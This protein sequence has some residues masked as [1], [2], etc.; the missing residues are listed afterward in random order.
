MCFV[1]LVLTG[2]QERTQPAQYNWPIFNE[3]QEIL[4][5]LESIDKKL[6]QPECH[7]PEKE[8]FLQKIQKELESQAKQPDGFVDVN[9]KRIQLPDAIPGTI[10]DLE[11]IPGVAILGLSGKARSGKDS[12]C[13]WIHSGHPTKTR[14]YAFADALKSFCRCHGMTTKDGN[15]LQKVG[16]AMREIDVEHWI[17]VCY[18]TIA[19]Q[20][21]RVALISDVRHVNEAEF[22]KRMGGQIIRVNRF[23]EDGS[24][25]IDPSR[26]ATHPSEVDLDDY[27][28]FD[29]VIRN[30][31]TLGHLNGE[32]NLAFDQFMS[33]VVVG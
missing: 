28:G 15:M 14:V 12:A 22:V 33:E 5:R 6:G 21:P 29:Y 25:F 32:A 17:K 7:D 31:R 19:E 24:P 2:M 13:A 10:A 27:P 3:F 11:P 9:G 23:N 8:K 16:G 30:D 1:S 4:R 26:S 20:R 18:F